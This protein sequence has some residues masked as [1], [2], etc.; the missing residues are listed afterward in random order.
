MPRKV[1]SRTYAYPRLKNT[2]LRDWVGFTAAQDSMESLPGVG[3]SSNPFRLPLLT[4]LQ[5]SLRRTV[6]RILP[7]DTHSRISDGVDGRGPVPGQGNRFIPMLQSLRAFT[8]L[9]CSVN[10]KQKQNKLHETDP[11]GRILGFLDRSRY[12]SI[13]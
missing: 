12:F 3:S 6:F 1:F 9:T 13:K 11:Y 4:E 2:A 5:M 10:S 8:E 7:W